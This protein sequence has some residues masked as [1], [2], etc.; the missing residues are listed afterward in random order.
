MTSETFWNY[1][2]DEVDS[3][4]NNASQLLK[5]NHLNIRNKEQEKHQNDQHNHHQIQMDLTHH[6]Y[7]YHT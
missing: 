3:A 7:K 2:R 1:Y 5:I 6:N 4:D